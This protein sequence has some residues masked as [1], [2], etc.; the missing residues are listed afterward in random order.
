MEALS[1]MEGA[2]FALYGVGVFSVLLGFIHFFMPYLLD[3]SKAIPI[4]GD[5]L[6]P[7]RF[8]SFRYDTKRSDIRG[9]AWVM[10]HAVSFTLVSI[11]FVDLSCAHWLQTGFGWVIALWIAVWWFLRALCQ[12]YLGRRSGDL[13]VMGWFLLLGMVHMAVVL[14]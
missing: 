13:M 9:I 2:E 14:S 3:F 5:A 4:E 1:R 6:K 11:G 8:L 10:N 7:F 12:L